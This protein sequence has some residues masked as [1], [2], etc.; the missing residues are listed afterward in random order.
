MHIFKDTKYNFLRWRFHAL[1]VSWVLIIAGAIMFA[2]VGIPLGIEFAGGT[3][4]IE[5]F[6]QAVSVD[7]V[8]TALNNGLGRAT[9]QN[10]IVQS[11]SDPA[12]H[13]VMIRVP[14]VLS[15]KGEE[16]TNVAEGVDGALAKA[17]LGTFKRQGST[18]VGPAVGSEL[19][20]RAFLATVFS[21][22]GLLVYI[23][24]RFQFSFA[25]GAVVATIHD[26]LITLAFLTFF[27][28]DMTLTV[29]AAI[30]TITGYSTNDTI[31]IF[32]R[33]R[34][35]LRSMRRDS[36]NEVI[37]SSVNQTL[38]RTVIVSGTVLLTA[39]ALFVFGGEVLKGFAFTMIVGVVTGTY[40]SVFIAA[41]T[42]SFWRG[43]AP[44]RAA[45]HAHTIEHSAPTPQQPT[46]KSKPQRKARAS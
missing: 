27:R 28:Y 39:I 20:S 24:F 23:A 33:I 37:N 1:A 13:E 25:V 36:M 8:R 2:K 10:A 30:L 12:K 41:A 5:Q 43:N 16:L 7:Q 34:E 29:I 35:N 11:F 15:E 4:V 26:L 21:L 31:V 17:S 38:G 6:D 14:S 42:V 9:G 18:I 22:A 3:E 19:K 45:A 40:S 44:T 46:R 32:D